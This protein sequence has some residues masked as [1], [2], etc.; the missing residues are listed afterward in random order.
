MKKIKEI[1]E[2]LDNNRNKEALL[3][4]LIKDNPYKY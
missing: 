1:R 4:F 2:W 3:R